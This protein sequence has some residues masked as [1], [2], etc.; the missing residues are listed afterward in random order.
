MGFGVNLRRF[1]MVS[2]RLNVV[3]MCD[4]GVVS[5]L[6]MIASF[7]VLGCFAMMLGSMLTMFRRFLMVFNSF[8]HF[9][10]STIRVPTAGWIGLARL[11]R[12]ELCLG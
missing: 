10:F 11:V 6:F 12:P 5:R 2:A 1:L 4:V 7:M 3:T 8:R 9:Q